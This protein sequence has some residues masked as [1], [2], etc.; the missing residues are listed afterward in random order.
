MKQ[1]ADFHRVALTSAIEHKVVDVE[2]DQLQLGLQ[3]VSKAHDPWS[4]VVLPRVCNL[5][6]LVRIKVSSVQLSCDVVVDR[7][8]KVEFQLAIEEA[9]LSSVQ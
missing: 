5:L 8:G 1:T 3:V 9:L 6:E 4:A 2:A 7:V